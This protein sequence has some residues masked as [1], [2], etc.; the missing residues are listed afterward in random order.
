M[1]KNEAGYDKLDTNEMSM[2]IHPYEILVD[3]TDGRRDCSEFLRRL[4]SHK[5]FKVLLISMSLNLD[6]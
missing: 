1:R 2:L 4:F 5:I 6:E 3:K